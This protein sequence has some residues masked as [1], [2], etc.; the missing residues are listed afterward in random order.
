MATADALEAKLA[1]LRQPRNEEEGH[2]HAMFVELER[3]KQ[4]ERDFRATC[5]AELVRLGSLTSAP[6]SS[7]S[8]STTTPAPPPTAEPTTTT[9]TT[10]AALAARSAL[11]S[12]VARQR[13]STSGT[14]RAE[15][16]QYSRRLAELA[17]LTSHMTDEH[18]ELIALHNSLVTR[19]SVAT[20]ARELIDSVPPSLV[21]PPS[22]AHLTDL[23]ASL[24]ASVAASRK[25]ADALAA[26]RDARERE[27]EELTERHRAHARAL[28]ELD[29]L[30]RDLSSM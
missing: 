1:E 2:V 10:T 14:T 22:A 28:R 6:V 18:R 20:K 5:K 13:A 26:A 9:T 29:E 30:A 27:L 15:M 8:A 16:M 17:S 4:H 12:R 21:N 24:D 11:T 23:L 19:A 25:R 7:S 3:I